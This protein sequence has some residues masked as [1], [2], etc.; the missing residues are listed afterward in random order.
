MSETT[1]AQVNAAAAAAPPNSGLTPA[2]ADPFEA[3]MSS[4]GQRLAQIEGVLGLTLP[5]A[6]EA[7]A[8]VGAIVPGAA[9]ILSRIG[10]IE[11][12]LEGV[13]GG[14]SQA[15]GDNP[16]VALPPP[17]SVTPAAAPPAS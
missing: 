11:S 6:N 3:F 14:L 5:I 15:F 17:G 2:P 13:L 4:V 9:P 8:V 1:Q 7:A 16:K 10:T 12:V